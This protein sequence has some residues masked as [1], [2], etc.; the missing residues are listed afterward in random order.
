M[1]SDPKGIPPGATVEFSGYLTKRSACSM[2]CNCTR[3]AWRWEE[4]VPVVLVASGATGALTFLLLGLCVRG[5][6]RGVCARQA[7]G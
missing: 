1:S 5:T 2:P 7:C 4:T 6:G 3:R